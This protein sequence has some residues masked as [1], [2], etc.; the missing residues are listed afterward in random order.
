MGKKSFIGGLNSILSGG[1]TSQDVQQVGEDPTEASKSVKDEELIP[2]IEASNKR[3]RPKT[4]YREIE[5]TSQEGCK[6]SE[7]RATFIINEAYLERIKALAYWERIQIKDAIND[8]LKEYLEKYETSHGKI[9][10]KPEK[11]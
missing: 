8:A 1:T 6:E 11:R 5:K 4:N 3:G 9:K 10:P 2:V 7:T